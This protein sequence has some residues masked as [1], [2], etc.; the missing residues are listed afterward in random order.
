MAELGL[1][2]DSQLRAKKFIAEILETQKV[3]YLK[4]GKYAI[5]SESNNYEDEEGN[6]LSIIPFW[7][8][9]Y[10][11]YA[12][13]WHEGSAI[14]ELPIES[15]I[16]YWLKGMNKDGLIVGLN[17]DQNG[18]GYECKPLELLENLEGIL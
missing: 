8:K 13:K 12:R 10:L 16:K 18:I 15:F 17:W 14:Q 2:I 4:Q 9:T 3:Y 6:P 11:P 7:S 5:E 1:E